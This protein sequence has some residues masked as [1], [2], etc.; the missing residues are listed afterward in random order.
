[1]MTRG[2]S[3]LPSDLPFGRDE[4]HAD[5]DGPSSSPRAFWSDTLSELPFTQAK[6]KAALAFESAY[7]QRLLKRTGNNVS[8]AARQAG[9]DR[10]NF[11]R[12]MK[13]VRAAGDDGHA[14]D[15]DG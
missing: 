11:R 15:E 6:E 1:V 14:E 7:V 12:L 5:E 3:I 10:S 8:E 9:M 4:A 13:K 2:D